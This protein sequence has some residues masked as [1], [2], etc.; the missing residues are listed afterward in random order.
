MKAT[1]Q[2]ATDLKS[3]I[4]DSILFTILV[5]VILMALGF[6][7]AL[8]SFTVIVWWKPAAACAILALPA[9]LWLARYLRRITSSVANYLEYPTA[10]VLSFAIL[11]TAFYASSYYFSDSST[12]YE[13]KAPVVRKY[14]HLRKY[15]QKVGRR[16]YK[17][18]KYYVYTIE[19]EMIDGKIKKLDKPLKEYNKIKK[20]S[21]LTLN[22]EKGLF[23]VPV[24]KNLHKSK[25]KQPK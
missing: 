6:A 23:S 18:V 9:T 7:V 8:H 15:Q 22:V 25:Q 4:V 14:S 10:Y 5:L 16:G 21:Y 2:N 1:H 13:Y 19:I 11:L 24:I 20:G 17:E 12:A 3:S